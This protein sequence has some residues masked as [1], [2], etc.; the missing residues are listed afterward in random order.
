MYH[1][2]VMGCSNLNIRCPDSTQKL[3]ASS[4]RLIG[5]S[6][7]KSLPIMDIHII[8]TNASVASIVGV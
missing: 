5:A 2:M 8:L 4:W 1:L 3:F 7:I 6:T